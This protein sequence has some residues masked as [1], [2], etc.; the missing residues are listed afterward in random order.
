MF[1]AVVGV[2]FLQHGFSRLDNWFGTIF[3]PILNAA[4]KDYWCRATRN[5]P[6][7]P[8]HR[9]STF[10]GAPHLQQ[11]LVDYMC[12]EHHFFEDRLS[13][14]L[15][16]PPK[17]T[18]FYYDEREYLEAP[19]SEKLQVAT[20][21]LNLCICYTIIHIWLQ[22]G[23]AKDNAA[24][25]SSTLTGAELL[26]FRKRAQFPSHSADKLPAD[27]ISNDLILSYLASTLPLATSL[28]EGTTQG[29][30]RSSKL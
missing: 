28:G 25:T 4:T 5:L 11:R 1:E 27:L 12:F 13:D 24:H 23:Y 6:Y 10:S 3:E 30:D 19:N 17:T 26:L 20:H 16:T 7:H 18:I 22:Y 15:Y 14:V 21:F 2:V 8:D 9:N 29:A